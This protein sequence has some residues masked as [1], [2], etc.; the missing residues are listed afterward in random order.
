MNNYNPICGCGTAK[1]KIT[2]GVVSWWECKNP[3]CSV[4]KQDI[5]RR[6]KYG[7]PNL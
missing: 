4:R 3:D 7:T 6:E 2:S 5:K 1:T